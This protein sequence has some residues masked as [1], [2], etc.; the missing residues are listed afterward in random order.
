MTEIQRA[1]FSWLKRLTSHEQS[2]LLDEL[3]RA[4][5]SEAEKDATIKALADALEHVWSRAIKS[6]QSMPR[7]RTAYDLCLMDT[8]IS[9]DT[10]TVLVEIRDAL[11]LAGRLP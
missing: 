10:N 1:S 9:I 3:D 11:R 6:G 5:Q 2:Q 7:P 4:R 8:A